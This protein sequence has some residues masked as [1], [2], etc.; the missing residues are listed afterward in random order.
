MITKRCGLIIKI[1]THITCPGPSGAK[2]TRHTAD[3]HP[4]PSQADR[5]PSFGK[6]AICCHAAAA[7]AA[8]SKCRVL[9][10]CPAFKNR[11]RFESLIG[12][13]VWFS[14]S[15]TAGICPGPQMPTFSALQ[16]KKEEKEPQHRQKSNIFS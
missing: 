6:K 11:S 1:K 16:Q 5:G 13:K 4:G 7:A 10:C 9:H 15:G 2:L 12:D 3:I 14:P 8:A